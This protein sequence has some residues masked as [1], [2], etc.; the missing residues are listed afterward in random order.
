MTAEQRASFFVSLRRLHGWLGL[1]GGVAG[2]L[3]GL[4]GIVQNHR[5]I[6][7]IPAKKIEQRSFQLQ[8][9]EAPKDP[10][11]L[12]TSLAIELGFERGPARQKVE[13]AASVVWNGREVL[14]PE[15]WQFWFEA[16]Q[17]FARADYYVGNRFV[18]VERSDANLFATLVR[19]HQAIG[20]SALWVLVA[21]TIAG[22]LVLLAL[23]GL[24]LWSRLQWR[25]AATL[26]VSLV[27]VALAAVA[28]LN[29]A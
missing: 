24:V 18:H 8:L 2:L 22:S 4:T 11:T 13:H 20:V 17:R 6:L 25:R 28:A 23:S 19:L 27:P 12:A 3:F 15:R 7:P 10:H 29:A 26:V 1:W 21:D 16:P 14:Q 9:A 5:S